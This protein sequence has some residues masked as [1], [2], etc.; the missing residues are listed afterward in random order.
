MPTG[1]DN[2]GRLPAPFYAAG[3]SSFSE[4]LSEVA[5]ELLPGRRPLPPG[6]ATEVSAHA[7]TIVAI[8]T[9]R[10]RGRWAATGVP[11]WATSSPSADI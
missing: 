1:L 10:G 6:M 7:T 2:S 8:A 3:T 11:R 9:H 5:P 4:F